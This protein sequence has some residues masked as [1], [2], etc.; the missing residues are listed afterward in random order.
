MILY[1]KT[2]PEDA[3]EIVKHGFNPSSD[4]VPAG[5]SGVYL[6]TTPRG[7]TSSS[8]W[9][10]GAILKVHV[11]DNLKLHPDID[12][13]PELGIV[14]RANNFVR[15][16]RDNGEE[17]REWYEPEEQD[18]DKADDVSQ[19]LSRKGFDGHYDS[20][21]HPDH[22]VIYNPSKIKVLSVNDEP[23]GPLN[24]KQFGM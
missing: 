9:G 18:F 21:D 16:Y 23:V 19:V 17:T 15:E 22:V 7:A 4:D 20:F 1:H 5:A 2:S 10:S 24:R 3:S 14:R 12:S 13:D 8:A 6:S 11:P